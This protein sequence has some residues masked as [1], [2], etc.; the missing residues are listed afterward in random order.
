MQWLSNSLHVLMMMR[1]T[2]VLKVYLQE[3]KFIMYL[4]S[5]D[6]LLRD[7]LPVR[8]VLWKNA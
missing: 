2:H 4:Q 5:L 6:T 7:I 3:C 1:Q 8:Y